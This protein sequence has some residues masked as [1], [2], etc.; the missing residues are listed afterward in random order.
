MNTLTDSDKLLIDRY[1]ANELEAHEY[2][3]WEQR[4]QD[5]AFSEAVASYQAVIAKVVDEYQQSPLKQQFKQA[6][7]RYHERTA[8]QSTPGKVV[9]L[10][11]RRIRIAAAI[12]AVAIVSLL[13]WANNQYSDS[14]IVFALQDSIL[15][16]A[17]MGQV[18]KDTIFPNAKGRFF[19]EDYEEAL[20][21]FSSVSEDSKHYPEAQILKA[22]T[23]FQLQDYPAAIGLFNHWIDRRFSDIPNEYRN[24]NK[25]RWTRLLALVGSGQTHSEFFSQELNYFLNSTSDYYRA[26]A[27]QLKSKMESPWRKVVL[28]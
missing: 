8:S 26:K 3:L 10:W 4:M 2:S 25:L 27:Q 9:S 20:N 19:Q 17:N 18:D 21:G 7:A 1:L 12:V 16:D 5:L 24:E 22:Y 6:G 14:A 28:F 23:L 15:D 11:S 13:G